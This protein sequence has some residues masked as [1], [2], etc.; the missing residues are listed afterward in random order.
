VFKDDGIMKKVLL[1]ATVQSHIAQFHLPLINML[2]ENGYEVHVAARNNLAEKKGLKLDT[3]D[4]IF[5]VAFDRSPL[6]RKNIAAY[7][8]L[9]NIID[10]E[11]Y[12]IIHCNTPVGGVITRLAARNSRKKGTR[13]IYTAHGFHFYKGAPLINWIIYYPIEKYM[14]RFTNDLITITNEDYI[15]AKKKKFKTVVHHVNG[16]GVNSNK[17]KKLKQE[18][19]LKLRQVKGYSKDDKIIL[20]IGELNENKNQTTVIKAMSH[21]LEKYLNTKLLLAGNGPSENKL[22]QLAVSLNVSNNIE[23]LGYRTDLQDYVN[24]CDITVSASIREGLPLN[25][26]EAMICGKPIVASI[27][28]G[29]QELVIDGQTGYLVESTDDKLFAEK[30]IDLMCDNNKA[31]TFGES[32]LQRIEPFDIVNVKEQLSKIYG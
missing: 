4:E 21:I 25:V 30:I 6:S 22:K 18:D 3:T 32:G 29:H 17:Y 23:F 2:K 26:M 12:D 15:F 27:N 5:D 28:R 10:K 7:K 20:C 9:K 19:I 8:E 31:M 13:V 24:L 1:T 14:A 16:V 11:N